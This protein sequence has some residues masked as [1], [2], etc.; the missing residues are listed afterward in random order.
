MDWLIDDSRPVDAD[1]IPQPVRG[2]PAHT[3]GAA[4]L[5]VR[6]QEI[7]IHDNRKWFGDAD[8]RI[9]TL[10]VH[11]PGRDGEEQQFYEPGTHRFGRVSDGDRLPIGDT[12]LLV[13]YGK[14]RHFLDIFVTVSRDRGDTRDLAA[15]LKDRLG[16]D[17]FRSAATTILALTAAAPHATA[18]VAAASAATTLGN[19]SAQLLHQLTGNTIGLYRTS[20]LQYRDRFGLGRH[21][22]AGEYRIKDLSFSFEIQLDRAAPVSPSEEGRHAEL[23]SPQP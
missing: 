1:A 6:L 20:F 13:F 17:D 3:R 11:G 12:G 5:A 21:P 7:T 4:N 18:I 14:P 15:L 9:D 23:R 2:A 10:V 8:I 19:L 16:S 22:E